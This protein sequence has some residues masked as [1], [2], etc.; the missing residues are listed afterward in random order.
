MNDYDKA[1]RVMQAMALSRISLATGINISIIWR[2]RD[3]YEAIEKAP[4]EL[5][6][7]I[8]LL[9]GTANVHTLG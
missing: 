5:V 4:I 3:R 9:Y 1:R 8:A 2:Y 6:H 7:K